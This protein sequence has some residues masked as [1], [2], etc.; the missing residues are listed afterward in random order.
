MLKTVGNPSTRYGDQTI[1]NGDLVIGTPGQGID[2][3]ANSHSAGMTK[4]VLDWYEEGTWTPTDAS[5]AGLTFAAAAGYFV[6]TGGLVVAT[7]HVVYPATANTS[8]ILIGGLPF[9]CMA[10][11]PASMFS[12]AVSLTTYGTPI[13][14]VVVSSSSNVGFNTF[15]AGSVTNA[16]M[17]GQ[18]LRFTAMYRV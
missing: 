8:G 10:T 12:A 18:I 9:P 16:N 2:F 14:G 5:G 4:E 7:A 13:A 3:S 17:S 11:P 15:G 1:I 6:R